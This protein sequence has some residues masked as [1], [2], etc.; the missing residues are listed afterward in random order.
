[1][2]KRYREPLWDLDS[3]WPVITHYET[4]TR[5]EW[6]LMDARTRADREKEGKG[7]AKIIIWGMILIVLL[8]VLIMF[9]QSLP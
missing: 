4:H 8:M 9:L 7:V 5:A 2:E 6:D 1:M 3:E